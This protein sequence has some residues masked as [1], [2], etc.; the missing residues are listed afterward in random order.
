MGA[1]GYNFQQV[2]VQQVKVQH[3]T[4]PGHT[5]RISAL[6][7]AVSLIGPC[8]H[9]R[10]VEREFL[11]V[12]RAPEALPG[13]RG[14]CHAGSVLECGKGPPLAPEKMAKAIVAR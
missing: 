2:K 7:G 8:V 10:A 3:S 5:R 9:D 11:F 12:L 6:S 4:K 1:V 14:A 13:A